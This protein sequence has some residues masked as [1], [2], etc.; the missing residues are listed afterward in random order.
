M[1]NLSLI[2]SGVLLIAVATLYYFVFSK[3]TTSDGSPE[4]SVPSNIKIAFINSDSILKYY[5]YFKLN[6][7]KLEIKGKKLEQDLKN[8]AQSFQSDYESY[9]R[10]QASLTIGQAKAI[11]EDLGKKQQNLQLYQQSLTQEITNDESKL[12]QSLYLKITTFL[13]KY[14]KE[15]G[16][17][18]VFKFDPSSD[19]LYGGE[20]LDITK[21]VIAGLNAEFKSEK[22]NSTG[23]KKDSIPSKK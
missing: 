2:L 16:L 20:S 1:K 15:K 4:I 12:T 6:R 11:E 21:E 13:K 5:D 10:N 17:Q 9:Q 19:I 18:V 14:A 7:E 22:A 23:A 3:R 8:R